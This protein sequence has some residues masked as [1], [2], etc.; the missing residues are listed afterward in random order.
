M[1]TKAER[2]KS[3]FQR[4]VVEQTG[5]LPCQQ[6]DAELWFA[7][8]GSKA[9]LKAKR[10]CFQDCPLL[11]LCAEYA[12]ENGVPNGIW[13]GVDEQE[14]ER[15]WKRR[16]AKPT[17]FLDEM[18]A[19]IGPALQARRDFENFDATHGDPYEEAA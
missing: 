10:Q 13:G 18:D 12:I 17:D 19:A 9:S 16:G 11:H 8:P 1:R 6:G 3:A 15:I 7:Q 14:R 2:T 5:A 4:A